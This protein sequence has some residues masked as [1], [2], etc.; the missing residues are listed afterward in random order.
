MAFVRDL[1]LVDAAVG[2]DVSFEDAVAALF[3]SQVP[4]IAVLGAHGVIG[5]FAE[6]DI[7]H[8]VFPRYLGVL[9]HTAF[10]GGETALRSELEEI[11]HRPVGTLARWVEPLDGGDGHL[12]AAERLMHGEDHA[13]PVVENGRFLGMLSVSALCTAELERAR[14]P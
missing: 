9:H 13:L 14:T 10:I 11:R 5:V 4:T 6:G 12:H 8:N 3:A 1:P 2:G 7:L